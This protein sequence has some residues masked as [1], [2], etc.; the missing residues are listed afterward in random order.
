MEKGF[1]LKNNWS[2]SCSTITVETMFWYPKVG[3]LA[4]TDI[5]SSHKKMN[6][7]LYRIFATFWI[8]FR[9]HNNKFVS[10]FTRLIFVNI[11]ITRTGHTCLSPS[12]RV[13]ITNKQ[14]TSEDLEAV[15]INCPVDRKDN[16][17]KRIQRGIV[18]SAAR[19]IILH[20][21]AGSPHFYHWHHWQQAL[22]VD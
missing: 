9:Q 12:V 20:A 2:V 7:V 21:L 13:L 16:R 11:N 3:V 1:I 5:F 15:S 10:S 17:R 22:M 18:F 14:N 19:S 8:T 4:F 6:H